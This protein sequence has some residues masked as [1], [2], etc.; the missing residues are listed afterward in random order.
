VVRVGGL[1]DLIIDGQGLLDENGSVDLLVDDGLHLFDDPVDD[2]LVNDGGIGDSLGHGG[3]NLSGREVGGS[4]SLSQ[5]GRVVLDDGGSSLGSQVD[6]SDLGGDNLSLSD[7]LDDLID[8]ELLSLSVDDRLDLDDFL[9]LVDFVD[10]GGLLDSLDEGGSLSDID[11]RGLV[12]LNRANKAESLSSLQLVGD[13]ISVEVGLTVRS[14]SLKVVRDSISVQVVESSNNSGLS[15][16]SLSLEVVWDSVSV[17]VIGT[18]NGDVSSLEVIG[19][20][21]SVEVIGTSNDSGGSVSLQNIG[22]SVAIHV[23]D[24]ASGSRLVGNNRVGCGGMGSGAM[25]QSI[26]NAIVVGILVV[27]GKMG[28]NLV[29]EADVSLL[30]RHL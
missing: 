29:L 25:L 5:E 27:A 17:E 30:L 1:D 7:G 26:G 4:R 28:L 19:D 15:V 2:G 11:D 8:V 9:S 12:G 22:D 24:G 13:S 10:D 14:L 23:R 18:S 16:R 21:I 20:S 3:G 6:F